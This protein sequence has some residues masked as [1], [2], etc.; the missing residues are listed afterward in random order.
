MTEINTYSAA[1]DDVVA[2]SGRPERRNDI[3]AY[4]RS[5]IR[6]CQAKAYFKRDMIEDQL[7]ATQ[8]NYI[9]TYPQE[10]RILR[11][12]E[13][14]GILNSRN[15][16]IW[17][18]EI[19]PGKRQR[20]VTYYY[21]GGPGYY[22]FAG[23]SLSELINV[24]YYKVSKKLAYYTAATRPATFSLEDNTW[25]YLNTGTD[26]ENLIAR[27]KVSNWLLFDYYDT[28]VEGGL[29]KILKTIDDPRARSTYALY[30][31]LQKTF[32]ETEPSDSL[33]K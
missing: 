18:K 8:D 6:E 12:V 1:V 2:R 17:P 32:I 25:S 7:T 15:E 3:I 13:Y 21:Y 11:T 31:S 14:P 10:F 33:N 19:L 27:N 5:T 16:T 29:A 26:A 23:T 9:W 4:V 28:I 20:E 22:V 30:Q 24:A